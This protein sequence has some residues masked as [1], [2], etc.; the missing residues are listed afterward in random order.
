MGAVLSVLLV[1]SYCQTSLYPKTFNQAY[2]TGFF[3]GLVV[4]GIAGM[5]ALAESLEG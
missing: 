1:T 5:F 4:G 3:W 2:H